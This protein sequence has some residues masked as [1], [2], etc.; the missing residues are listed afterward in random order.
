[1]GVPANSL[2]DGKTLGELRIRTT[3]GASV[4][5][6]I[7]AGGFVANPDGDA[8]LERGD[9][10]AVLGTR[11]QISRFETALRPPSLALQ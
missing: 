11:E 2:F 7:R 9:L 5:G 1:M 8:R 4:V 6:I 3:I 10:V